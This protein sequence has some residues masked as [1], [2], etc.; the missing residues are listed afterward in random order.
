MQPLTLHPGDGSRT[1]VRIWRDHVQ[2]A[3]QGA[4]AADWL[5]TFLEYP[6]RLVRLPED[7]VRPVDPEFATRADDQVGLADGFPV[8]LI[9]EESL[10]DLNRRLAA[11][12]PMNRFRPNVVVS[13]AGVP[14]AEDTWREIQIGEVRFSLVKA[15]ARCITT[16]TD[17]R[18][19]ERGVEPLATLAS[20]RR[21]PRGV[22]FGQNLVHAG[23]GRIAVG[24]PLEVCRTTPP[25]V[26]IS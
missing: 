9:S 6:C 24:D 22:L 14:F 16:T 25:P 20:Y 11:P 4:A 8:L 18:T 26:F 15:C 2:V 13:G 12:L 10:A 7:V 5:S 17:Q 3:D 19:A 21:V 23:P 1:R